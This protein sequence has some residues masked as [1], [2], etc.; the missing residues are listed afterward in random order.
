LLYSQ[1]IVSLNN[2][3][4]AVAEERKPTMNL[5]PKKSLVSSDKSDVTIIEMVVIAL[6][7]YIII[8]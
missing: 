4:Q 6:F 8:T 5:L 1:Y 7:M 2:L 3:D